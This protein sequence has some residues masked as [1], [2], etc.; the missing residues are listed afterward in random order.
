[1]DESP[2][3]EDSS[4]DEASAGHPRFRMGL[5]SLSVLPATKEV[6]SGNRN[7]LQIEE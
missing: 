1:M 7:G 2:L 6:G 3:K 4:N 5:D